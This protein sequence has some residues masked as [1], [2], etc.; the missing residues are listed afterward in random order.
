MI[1]F[2]SELSGKEFLSELDVSSFLPNLQSQSANSDEDCTEENGPC[3]P[4]SPYRTFN[5]HCNNPERPHLGKSLTTFARL[6]PAVYENGKINLYYL[7]ILD[8]GFLNY[9]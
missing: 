6:L 3:D 7:L 9:C 1:G 8:R 4:R 2:G 5:G